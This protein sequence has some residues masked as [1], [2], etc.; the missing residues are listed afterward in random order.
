LTFFDSN[1]KRFILVGL[2]DDGTQA[3]LE[4]FDG[5][6]L[7]SGN[8]VTRSQFGVAGAAN[9]HSGFGGG[10]AGA[11]GTTN[12]VAFGSSLDGTTLPSTVSLYDAAGNLRT[13]LTVKPCVNYVGFFSGTYTPTVFACGFTGPSGNE[14]IIGNAYDNS[15]SYALLYDSSSNLRS[16]VEYDPATNFNGS[17]SQDGAGHNLSLVGNFVTTEASPPQQANESFLDLSD[18]SGT[19]RLFEFQNSTNEGGIDFNPGSTTVQGDWGN[20]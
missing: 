3:G 12:R 2:S 20:P 11:D 10:V 8:G 19:L 18:T 1:G 9:F 15:A 5:N 7:A 17:F 4:A 6:T 16:G 13:G 14:S